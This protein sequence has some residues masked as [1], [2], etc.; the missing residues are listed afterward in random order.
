MV[1]L[2]NPP[3]NPCFGCGPEHA[4]GLRLSFEKTLGADGV[5]EIQSTFT[6][7]TDE[8]GWPGIFHTGLHFTVLYEVSYWAALTLGGRL[9]AYLLE[10]IRE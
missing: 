6:P 3:E 7:G 1:R 5:E 10:E 8:V 2:E 9:I 4:R